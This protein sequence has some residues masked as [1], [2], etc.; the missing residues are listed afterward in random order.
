[1]N[2]TRAGG[3]G[4]V[5]LV[6]PYEDIDKAGLGIG[7]KNIFARYKFWFDIP[8]L[9]IPCDEEHVFCLFLRRK[10]PYMGLW[11]LG[12]LGSCLSFLMENPDFVQFTLKKF[13]H[14]Y[15]LYCK[16]KEAEEIPKKNPTSSC[17]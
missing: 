10:E 14:A 11:H 16:E 2:I 6:V 9:S 13:N 1:M 5:Q 17:C 8:G 3:F 12:G 7:F 4:A 15:D